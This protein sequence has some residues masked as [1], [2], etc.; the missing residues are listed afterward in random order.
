MAAITLQGTEFEL[1]IF[2][3][4]TTD[5][6]DAALEKAQQGFQSL[7][8]VQRLNGSA[9]RAACHAVFECVNTIFGEGTDHKIFGDRCNLRDAMQ[10]MDDLAAAIK[11]QRDAF[12]TDTDRL[13][14]KYSPNR[15]A[16]RA[17]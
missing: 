3:A 4:D 7:S 13:V 1:D 10:V 12:E 17:K 11:S 9:I 15:A 6:V 8:N 5:K 2:D 16:R 14:K